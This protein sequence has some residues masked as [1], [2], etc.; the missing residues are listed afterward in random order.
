[1]KD[2]KFLARQDCMGLHHVLCFN[3]SWNG[4][5]Q[6][7]LDIWVLLLGWSDEPNEE[8]TVKKGAGPSEPNGEHTGEGGWSATTNPSCF[9]G[10]CDVVKVTTN[11]K[12]I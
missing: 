3:P 5:V 6:A 12:I 8:Q 10:F 7:F 2:L 9:S 11:H 4:F 1:M